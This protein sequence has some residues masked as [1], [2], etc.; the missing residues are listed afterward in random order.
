MNKPIRY[1]ILGFGLHGIRRLVPAFR[2]AKQ[3]TLAGIWRRDLAKGKENAREFS[4]PQAFESAEALCASPEID[5]VFVTVEPKGGS[6]KPTGKPLL[7]ASLHIDP[8]HP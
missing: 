2:T 4:I 7:Y 3:S 8:N 1:G 5:A 6:A